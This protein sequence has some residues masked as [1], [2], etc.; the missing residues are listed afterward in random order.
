MNNIELSEYVIPDLNIK[1]SNE[2]L[3]ATY[4]NWN[5][6]LD[7]T[8]HG[9]IQLEN[10]RTLEFAINEVSGILFLKEVSINCLFNNSIVLKYS[11]K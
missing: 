2:L 1:Y 10:N 11:G 7:L 4:A 9:L 6:K 8:R 3:N 5:S